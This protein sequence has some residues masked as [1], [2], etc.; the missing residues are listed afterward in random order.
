MLKL[1]A[2]LFL[3]PTLA[4]GSWYDQ[5]LEGWYYF[6]DQQKDQK[7]QTPSLEEADNYLATESR[8]IK[9][10]LSLAIVS[11]TPENVENYIRTQKQ[12]VQQSSL[13]AQAWGKVLLE[14]P[15]LSDIINTPTSSYGT[16]A[17]R[18]LSLLQRKNLLRNL[19]KDY[20]LLFFFKGADPFSKKAA[21]VAEL[22]ASTNQ[23]NLKSVSLDN[24]GTSEL[25]H[26]ETDKGIS[27]HFDLQVTPCFY[28]VNPTD[29]QA[30]PVG[31]G[32]ISVSE[33]EENIENQFKDLI[34]DTKLP[35][36]QVAP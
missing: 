23:W 15:E 34:E 26:F 25:H 1:L 31:A 35:S 32:M 11:P 12:W 2:P 19:S 6:Q 7:E 14:H 29:N 28:I 9:Q 36:K 24:L 3:I 4:F 10:L 22:F 16:L 5:K 20:F 33:I 13:F 18:E 8:K 17:K 27:R 30:L 21:E